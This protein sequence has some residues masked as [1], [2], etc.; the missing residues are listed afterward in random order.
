VNT[1][2]SRFR[3]MTNC[4][5]DEYLT[6]LLGY[7]E[8]S[9]LRERFTPDLQ[10]LHDLYADMLEFRER[11]R[12]TNLCFRGPAGEKKTPGYFDCVLSEAN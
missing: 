4:L 2:F 11:L 10:P 12:T 1:Y 5:A 9:E 7:Y 6:P 8:A 3:Q